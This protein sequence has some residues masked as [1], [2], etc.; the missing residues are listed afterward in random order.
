MNVYRGLKIL[1][2]DIYYNL[3]NPESLKE[4]PLKTIPNDVL[5]LILSQL[6]FE[7]ILKLSLVNKNWKIVSDDPALLKYVIYKDKLF[8]PYKFK[9]HLGHDL[10]L[11]E[12]QKAWE[13]L[14]NNIGEIFK[15]PSLFSNKKIGETHL[16]AWIP[17]N[18]NI[19]NIGK[20][21]QG[22][23]DDPDD[24]HNINPGIL[25]D[26]GNHSMQESA[27]IA[28][29]IMPRPKRTPYQRCCGEVLDIKL[30]QYRKPKI[31]EAIL[32]LSFIYFKAK[33]NFKT[34]N[35]RFSILDTY[36]QENFNGQPIR[37]R[38]TIDTYMWHGVDILSAKGISVQ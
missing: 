14:P 38:F 3:Q 32:C 22:K 26:F 13:S 29:K 8:N 34:R 7:K 2:N 27:W 20:L 21:F 24:Y 35:A 23:F 25:K 36:C 16:F 33:K 1:Y 30:C 19:N 4:G 37:V 28:I 15:G 17:K 12:N 5:L 9:L 10:G 18:A 6:G 11:S 31:V